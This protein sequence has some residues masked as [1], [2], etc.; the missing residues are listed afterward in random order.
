MSEQIWSTFECIVL[1][2][3]VLATA[4]QDHASILKNYNDIVFYSTTPF[5]TFF[6]PDNVVFREKTSAQ[7]RAKL[8]H[9]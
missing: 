9:I 1:N 4:E 5:C 2:N 6:L 3:I 7:I 8:E